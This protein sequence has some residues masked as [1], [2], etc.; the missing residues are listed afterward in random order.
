MKLFS[1]RNILKNIPANIGELPGISGHA[2]TYCPDI[3]TSSDQYSTRFSGET[4]KFFLERQEEIFLS[5][6]PS[7]GRQLSVLDVGGGH[8]QLTPALLAAGHKIVVHGSSFACK[9]RISYLISV[10]GDLYDLPFSSR[11]FDLVMAFRLLPHILDTRKF[12]AELCQISA[13]QVI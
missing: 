12:L 2:H 3:V 6:L 10:E 13:T 7:G 4:G 8:G 5:F 1:N 9:H 11:S